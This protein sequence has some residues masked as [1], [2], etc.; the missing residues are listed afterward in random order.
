MSQLWYIFHICIDVLY[1]KMGHLVKLW[2][3]KDTCIFAPNL[4]IPL[5]KTDDWENYSNRSWDKV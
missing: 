4:Y 2:V 5:Q 3:E 1:I